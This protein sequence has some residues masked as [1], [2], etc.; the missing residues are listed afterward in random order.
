M[1]Y[2]KEEGKKGYILTVIVK[3][4]ARGYYHFTNDFTVG[5]NT[6]PCPALCINIT[7]S[8]TK[9]LEGHTVTCEKTFSSRHTSTSIG[10]L[11]SAVSSR[12]RGR[13]VILA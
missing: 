1:H 12:G 6:T 9:L 2:R 7:G 3:A 13:R 10:D 4:L 5:S 8:N 11:L